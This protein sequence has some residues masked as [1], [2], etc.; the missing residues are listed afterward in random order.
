MIDDRHDQEVTSFMADFFSFR[1]T[2]FQTGC[3]GG[4]PIKMRF[5]HILDKADLQ[6]DVSDGGS[7]AFEQVEELPRRWR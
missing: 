2:T 3:Y 5:I 6:E 1:K 4:R 7:Q